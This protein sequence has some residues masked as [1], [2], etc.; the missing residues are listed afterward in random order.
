M[1]TV[2]NQELNQPVLVTCIVQLQNIVN[3]DS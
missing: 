3:H 2:V 1:T